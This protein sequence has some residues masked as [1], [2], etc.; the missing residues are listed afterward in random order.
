MLQKLPPDGRDRQTDFTVVQVRAL[1]FPCRPLIML[2]IILI[3]SF[4][5]KSAVQVWGKGGER[6]GDA[7]HGEEGGRGQK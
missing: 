7:E 3:V 2:G 6:D 1:C 4:C 5:H